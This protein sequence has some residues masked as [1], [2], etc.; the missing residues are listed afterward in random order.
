LLLSVCGNIQQDKLLGTDK[1]NSIKLKACLNR[2]TLKKEGIIM[3]SSNLI[4]VKIY[5]RSGAGLSTNKAFFRK[6]D[7]VCKTVLTFCGGWI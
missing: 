2:K 1:L 4:V 3:Q 5:S 6:E 7:L